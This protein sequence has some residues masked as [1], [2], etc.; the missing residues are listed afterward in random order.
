[1]P[2]AT[3]ALLNHASSTSGADILMNA[4]EF[5][6]DK[7]YFTSLPSAPPSFPNIHFFSVD[8]TLVYV[9]FYSDFGPSNIAHVVRFCD[10]LGE[11]FLNSLTANKKICLYSSLESDKRAN[12]AFLMCAYM[13]IVHNLTPDEAHQP[14]LNIAPPFLPYRDAGY[15]AATYHITVLDCLR[16]LHKALTLGLLDLE[17]L[18]VSEYE[19]Y[20]RVENG[21]FNWIS[22][23]FLALASPKDDPPG[24]PTG[25]ATS[26][27]SNQQPNTN[28]GLSVTTRTNY[29]T[30][31]NGSYS[32]MLA[33]GFSS[34]VSS[35][36]GRTAPTTSTP[37]S[38]N[39]PS[40]LPSPRLF[41]AYRMDDL[42]RFM[43]NRNVRT[44]VRLNNKIYDRSRF[45]QA[46][47]DHIEMYFPDG[48]TPPEGILKRFLDLC[49]SRAGPIAV[50]C[51]AGLGRTGTLIAAY[52]MKH[53]K[54]TASEVISYLRIVR[55]GSVVGP[56]Q[57]YLQSMQAK[58]W[59][60]HPSS[61]LPTQISCLT[62]P[63]YPN[64][65]RWSAARAAVE[66]YLAQT[67]LYNQPTQRKTQQATPTRTSSQQQQQQQYQPPKIDRWATSSS[68]RSTK[69]TCTET[70]TSMTDYS[71]P[72]SPMQ[73]SDADSDSEDV[74]QPFADIN[75]GSGGVVTPSQLDEERKRPLGVVR[76]AYGGGYKGGSSSRGTNWGGERGHGRRAS[77]DLDEL[78]ADAT[79][80]LGDFAI[81][82]Q[83]RKHLTGSGPGTPGSGVG[84][85][86]GGGVESPDLMQS[87]ES[88]KRTVSPPSASTTSNYTT[89]S[90]PFSNA[91]IISSTNSPQNA[92]NQQQQPRYN[93]R[94]T[95][96]IQAQS[97]AQQGQGMRS[98][99]PAGPAGGAAAGGGAERKGQSQGPQL[100]EFVL[101]GVGRGRGKGGRSG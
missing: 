12:S 39:S 35:I 40:S 32:S 46:G 18:D 96:T 63:T 71:P 98:G 44:I 67:M 11:K 54:F 13:L 84:G 77:S 17:S 50:H 10:M 72:D 88:W 62:P 42:I 5:I 65:R 55:P 33:T 14:L 45:E 52:F 36:I 53:Y 64:L 99:M 94:S 58:F 21:D 31:A 59:K 8:S 86:F 7:L 30:T 20:E 87:I 3:T 79:K 82:V 15:G 92:N 69:P 91:S 2:Y 73:I 51:K 83:P 95:T 47:I 101:T 24:L 61:I 26:V 6:K 80:L 66:P 41:S 19:F 74:S 4:R 16:G 37:S 25:P 78:G 48:T 85:G 38:S 75:M 9:N 97:G 28:G 1:M 22:N 76:D 29:T 70:D 27:S 34:A 60:L 89:S 49:E 56:Q 23:K 90:N 100:S 93:F 57:N 81:P 68:Q 43:L